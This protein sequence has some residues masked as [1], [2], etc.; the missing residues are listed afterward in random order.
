MVVSWRRHAVSHGQSRM[1]ALPMKIMS[2]LQGKAPRDFF[3]A[4]GSNTVVA[5]LTAMSGI[6]AARLLGPAGRGELA[7]AVVWAG[8]LGTATQLGLPQALIYSTARDAEALGAI[9]RAT[10]VLY[11]LQNLGF[12]LLGWLLVGF[13]LQDRQPAL[14]P[15]VRA[16]LFSIPLTLPVTYMAA[17]AQGL[18]RF[19]LAGALRVGSAIGY[20]FSFVLAAVLGLHSAG[21]VIMVLLV[22]HG[23]TLVAALVYFRSRLLIPGR[24][25]WVWVKRL[26]SFGMR[27]YLGSLSWVANARIDQ[28]VMSAFVSLE[29][30]GYYAVAASYAGILFPILA[31]FAMVLFPHVAAGSRDAA[32]NK[33]KVALTLNFVAACGG[34]LLL[35]VISFYAIP[36]LFGSA[37]TPSIAPALILLCGT[38]LLSCNY[39]LS[40]GLRGLGHPM[41]PSIGE[42]AG[43]IMTLVALSL[44]LP[45]WGIEGAAVASLLSYGTSLLVLSVGVFWAFRLNTDPY[46]QR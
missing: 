46:Q 26:L 23:I 36:L 34:A 16:Y 3:F 21:Q 14:V 2:L 10:F 25:E 20:V 19:D 22:M 38:V 24:F 6:L 35:G 15:V 5:F 39:V 13:V 42:M 1:T 11:V 28:F 8:I 41:I 31:A 12:L 9:V 33:I 43:L 29:L 18:S 32:R 7:A 45:K 27:S 37:F 40:D 44:L 4:A 17:M 30:L